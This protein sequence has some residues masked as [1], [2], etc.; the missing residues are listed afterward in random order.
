MIRGINFRTSIYTSDISEIF[1]VLPIMYRFEVRIWDHK[2]PSPVTEWTLKLDCVI[3][4]ADL[5]PV[6]YSSAIN[7]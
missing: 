5:W 3:W 2:V 4:E 6:H 1:K 7:L